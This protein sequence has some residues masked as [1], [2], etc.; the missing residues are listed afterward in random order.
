M[1][2]RALVLALIAGCADKVDP[3]ADTDVVDSDQAPDTDVVVPTGCGDGIVVAPEACDDGAAN[4]DDVPDACRTTCQVPRC[5]DGVT[6]AGEGCDDANDLGGD[7]CAPGCI[8]E[9]LPGET[10]PNDTPGTATPLTPGVGAV[11]G[12]T[13]LDTDCWSVS[14]V[15]NGWISARAAGPD[16][17]CPPDLALRLFDPGGARVLTTVGAGDCARITPSD[18]PE[19]A[20]LDAG[21]WTVC[22]EGL[23]RSSVPAYR[24]EVETGD[25]SCLGFDPSPE[26]DPDGDGL[27]NACDSDD[28]G[29]GV[30]DGDDVCPLVPDGP[31]TPIARTDSAGFF[32][33][34]L[35]AAGVRGDPAGPGGSCDPSPTARLGA[36][37]ATASPGLGSAAG[38]VPLRIW[39][40]PTPSINF[41]DITNASVPREAYAVTWI[42]LDAP[43]DAVLHVGNDDGVV[44]WVDGVE[45]GRDS[46]CQG[47]VTDDNAWPVTLSAGWHRFTFKIRD[48][49]GSWGLVARLKDTN[50]VPLDGLEASPT[51][52]ARWNRNQP[53]RDGDGLGDACDPEP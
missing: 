24:I 15:D 5:G 53:D 19:A 40:P 26:D 11:G 50:G 46:A 14:V 44:A 23:L 3:P 30:L 35:V 25:D 1:V 8:A 38:G 17:Q 48:T 31:V 9:T 34:W 41:L 22:V 2:R 37:D 20:Y 6:D 33:H 49:G 36:D 32:R 18:D 4:A 39:M 52:P 29:D 16:G 13:D 27:A 45:V 43:I 51:G 12:L 10:E 42:T 47:V 7:G 21:T 28:D